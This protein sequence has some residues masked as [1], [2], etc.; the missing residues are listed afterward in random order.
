MRTWLYTSAPITSRTCALIVVLLDRGYTNSLY[1]LII[2][3]LPILWE[4]AARILLKKVD[5][6]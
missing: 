1:L 3:S 2:N 5:F 6:L 4:T